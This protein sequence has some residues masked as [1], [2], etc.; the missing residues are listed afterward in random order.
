M[1]ATTKNLFMAILI[2]TNVFD[3]ELYLLIFIDFLCL[4]STPILRCFE[5]HHALASRLQ[6]F[7]DHI[8]MIWKEYSRAL[9]LYIFP[10]G[11]VPQY[12]IDYVPN[13]EVQKY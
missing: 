5:Y 6:N 4:T 12:G 1:A 2:I 9:M 3:L 8:V 13:N 10:P 11:S 7:T